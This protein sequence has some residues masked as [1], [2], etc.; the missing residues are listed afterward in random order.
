MLP[1]KRIEFKTNW[2][3]KTAGTF[4]YWIEEIPLRKLFQLETYK[5]KAV[6]FYRQIFNFECKEEMWKSNLQIERI[7]I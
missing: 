3:R 2:S 7:N 6:K 1:G 5:L 4:E